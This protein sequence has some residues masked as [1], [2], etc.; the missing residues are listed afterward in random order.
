[1]F[2]IFCIFSYFIIFFIF[3]VNKINTSV[4]RHVFFKWKNKIHI[5]T[6]W[7]VGCHNASFWWS[8]PP[9]QDRCGG[10]YKSGWVGMGPLDPFLGGCTS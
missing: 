7:P 5:I 9:P 10:F 3:H 4:N 2:F 8:D 1:M 6:S